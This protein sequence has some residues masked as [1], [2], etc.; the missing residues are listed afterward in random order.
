MMSVLLSLLLVRSPKVIFTLDELEQYKE[1][2]K[3]IDQSQFIDYSLHYPKSRFLH[4]LSLTGKYVFHGSNHHDLEHFEPFEQTLYTGEITKAVFASTEPLWATFFAIFDR[5]KLVGSFRNGCIRGRNR[6]YHYYSINESTF[7]NNPWTE[8]MIYILPKSEF[9]P[10]GKGLLRFD[11]WIC[12]HSVTPTC[13]M[14][15]TRSDFQL[16]NKVAI[17]KNSE[18]LFKTWILYKMRTLFKRNSQDHS[19]GGSRYE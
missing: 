11:E 4:Y 2:S 10:S 16:I 14:T 12:L 5:H 6:T 13:K 8:G 15:V 7:R 1:L 3:Q 19:K 18:S 17:H 9:Q